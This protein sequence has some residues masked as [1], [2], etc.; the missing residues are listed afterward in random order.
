MCYSLVPWL[1]QEVGGLL[2]GWPGLNGQP[3]APGRNGLNGV[4]GAQGPSGPAG[5]TGVMGPVGAPGV[6]GISG[7]AGPR[8]PAGAVGV[9]GPVGRDGR[10]AQAKWKQ[11]AWSEESDLDNGVIKVRCHGLYVP[12]PQLSPVRGTHHTFNTMQCMVNMMQVHQLFTRGS[13]FLMC[14][15]HHLE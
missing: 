8:G 4:D 14:F 9:P 3:G 5:E 10:A 1:L 7:P 2:M 13:A 12:V 15:R 6:E 11:C